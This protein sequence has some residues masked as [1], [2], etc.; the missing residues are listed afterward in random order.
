MAGPLQQWIEF[1]YPASK[2]SIETAFCHGHSQYYGYT[3]MNKRCWDALG[4]E[5][6]VCSADCRRVGFVST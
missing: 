4:R 1:D 6:V 5:C 2:E 3:L